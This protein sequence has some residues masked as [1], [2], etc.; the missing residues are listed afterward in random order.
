MIRRT[1]PLKLIKLLA[2]LHPAAEE[3]A[4][5]TE[6]FTLP[7]SYSSDEGSRIPRGIKKLSD[8]LEQM[9]QQDVDDFVAKRLALK[10]DIAEVRMFCVSS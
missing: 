2:A 10:A 1:T 8:K 3:C 5:V 4:K 9:N 7:G 6:P